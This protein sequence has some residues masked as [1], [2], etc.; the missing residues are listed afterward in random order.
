M[1][2]L[3]E[4]FKGSDQ[5]RRRFER[6]ARTAAVIHHP[7]IVRLYHA[8]CD[9]DG[10]AWQVLELL[11]GRDLASALEER[12]LAIGE[13]RALADQLLSA[14]EAVHTRGFVHRDVK[15]ENVFLLDEAPSD[16]PLAI[17]LLDFGIAKPL[18]PTDSLPFITEEG[19]LLGTPHYMAP[20]QVTGEQ[21]VSPA[22]DL[23][24]VGAV[25][26]TALTGRAP[27]EEAQLSRLLVRIA[28]EPAP[29]VGFY[30]P[31]V[32]TDLAEV[33]ARA[34]RTHPAHRYHSARQMRAALG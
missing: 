15:P 32:P 20:E 9:P 21:P 7:H 12:P 31:D 1:K 5:Q 23:W 17:K 14:I 13:V 22:T 33:V 24:A 29:S 10:T 8:G 18:V 2:I 27:F 19:V 25:L 6:E 30:R 34:L 26:F 3:H 16:A 4:R 28:R 11:A